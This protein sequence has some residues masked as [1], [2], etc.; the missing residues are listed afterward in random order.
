[1]RK[2]VTLQVITSL[3]T[4]IRLALGA[5]YLTPSTVVDTNDAWQQSMPGSNLV[6]G[7]F[8]DG[9]GRNQGNLGPTSFISFDLGSPKQVA[10]LYIVNRDDHQD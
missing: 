7:N 6:D 5:N 9:V 8:F 10:S 3:L 4:S 2:L 1:M